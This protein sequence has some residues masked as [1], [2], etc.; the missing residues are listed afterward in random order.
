MT[1]SVNSCGST[2]AE[3]SC[4]SLSTAGRHSRKRRAVWHGLGNAGSNIPCAPLH[5]IT[6]RIVTVN[7][8]EGRKWNREV[9]QNSCPCLGG[10]KVMPGWR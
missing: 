6:I 4:C 3:G 8:L 7:L 2:I 10:S 1:L 9:L 5:L